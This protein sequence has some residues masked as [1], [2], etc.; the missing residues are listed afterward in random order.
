M[1][2]VISVI[3]RHEKRNTEKLMLRK[4]QE[5]KASELD[6]CPHSRRHDAR[7]SESRQQTMIP[8]R[9]NTGPHRSLWI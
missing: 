3:L 7:S 9:L 5:T 1:I 6:R 2:K 8:S 4:N